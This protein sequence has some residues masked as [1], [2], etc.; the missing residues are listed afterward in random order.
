M[1]KKWI[2]TKGKSVKG[3]IEFNVSDGIVGNRSISYDFKT[4]K[5]ANRMCKYLEDTHIL[6]AGV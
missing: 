2:V 5:E 1:N 6:R 4:R 3:E